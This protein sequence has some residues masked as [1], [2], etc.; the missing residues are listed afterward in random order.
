MSSSDCRY[1]L[2]PS[3]SLRPTRMISLDTLRT[4]TETKEL[5]GDR[6]PNGKAKKDSGFCRKD[7]FREDF[8]LDKIGFH[9]CKT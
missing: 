5:I 3:D 4:Q 8:I 7:F 2:V 1:R 9:L 6:T